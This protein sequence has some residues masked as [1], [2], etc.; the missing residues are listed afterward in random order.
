MHSF[1][2]LAFYYHW[3]I[4]NFAQ[5]TKCLHQLVGPTNVKETK[6]KKVRKEVMTLEDKKSDLTKPSFFWASE[7]W[8]AFDALKVA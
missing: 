1:I 6:G 3:F 8:K 4:P 5:V 7:H 2:G